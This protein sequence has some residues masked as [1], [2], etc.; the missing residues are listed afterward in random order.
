MPK[1][2]HGANAPNQPDAA[3]ATSK[4]TVDGLKLFSGG[5][6]DDWCRSVFTPF[7]QRKKLARVLDP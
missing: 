4:Q 3:S 1:P 2:K 5:E 6:F 7:L